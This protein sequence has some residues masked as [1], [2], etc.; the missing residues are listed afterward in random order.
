MKCVFCG[1]KLASQSKM[2]TSCDIC[3]E[4]MGDDEIQIFT[5]EADEIERLLNPCGKIQPMLYD[6]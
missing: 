4:I 2:E 1:V 6:E 3:K 5:D